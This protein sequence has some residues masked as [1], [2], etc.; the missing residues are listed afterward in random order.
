MPELEASEKSDDEVE[1]QN[2][3]GLELLNK[4]K[5]KLEL[6]EKS[7]LVKKKPGKV[8]SFKNLRTNNMTGVN[9]SCSHIP[10]LDKREQRKEEVS[11]SQSAGNEDDE[12]LMELPQ[13]D[14]DSM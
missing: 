13:L 2:G 7:S 14:E 9:Q 4:V 10:T 5:T 3:K 8:S 11:E 1:V 12:G 6:G